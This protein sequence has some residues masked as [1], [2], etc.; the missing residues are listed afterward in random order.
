MR[1]MFL[2]PEPECVFLYFTYMVFGFFLTY[3][4][5]KKKRGE[6]V[7]EGRRKKGGG[8]KKRASTGAGNYAKRPVGSQLAVNHSGL[9]FFHFL[10]SLI[11]FTL[12]ASLFQIIFQSALFLSRD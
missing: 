5:K 10:P 8:R 1:E 12:W 11:L 2:R 4:E 6:L 9:L 7:E 3:T